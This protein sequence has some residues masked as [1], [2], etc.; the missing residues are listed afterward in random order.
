MKISNPMKLG[1]VAAAAAICFSLTAQAEEY[2][3][4]PSDSTT[5]CQS[6]AKTDWMVL[7]GPD[8]VLVARADGD[9]LNTA[10]CVSD[11]SRSAVNIRW[12]ANGYWKTSG[13]LGNGCAEILG[14]SKVKVR[15]VNTNFREIATYY[16]CVQE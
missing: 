3:V 6:G 16:R 5:V 8:D 9:K 7:E 13:N 10:I 2:R 15:A 4:M 14:A 12:R 1:A 11:E